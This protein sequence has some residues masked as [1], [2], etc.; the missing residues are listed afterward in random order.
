LN[1]TF[2]ESPAKDDLTKIIENDNFEKLII[3]LD[4]GDLQEN[5]ERI[6]LL[7]WEKAAADTMENFKSSELSKSV[8]DEWMAKV[9]WVIRF[10]YAGAIVLKTASDLKTGEPNQLY[11]DPNHDALYFMQTHRAHSLGLETAFLSGMISSAMVQ[12]V[13]NEPLEWRLAIEKGLSAAHYLN[14]AGCINLATDSLQ[15]PTLKFKET[16]ELQETVIPRAIPD[17]WS[18]LTSFAKG[19][20]EYGQEIETDMIDLGMKTVNHGIEKALSNV[21]IAK[22]GNLVT[23]DRWEIENLHTISKA[24]EDYIVNTQKVPLSIGIF[25]EP[26]AGKSFVIGAIIRRVMQNI[27]RMDFDATEDISYDFPV[28]NYNLSHFLEYSDLL[29]RFQAIRDKAV[30]GQIPIVCFDNFDSSFNEELG[31]L[32]FFIAPMQDGVFSDHGHYRPIGKAIFF[33]IG[34]TA[35]TFETFQSDRIHLIPAG[36]VN[37]FVESHESSVLE[38]HKRKS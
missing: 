5:G 28:L 33:F 3:I 8:P 17:V 18:I 35:P 13:Q 38:L 9:E 25:G 19:K 23:V 4:V 24:M 32:K 2:G 12:I 10:G 27:N 15:Y 36:K 22:F 21:P 1:N 7:S 30:S 29:T 11:F 34:S 31:W 16:I 26:G 14:S 37:P 20:G 6:S